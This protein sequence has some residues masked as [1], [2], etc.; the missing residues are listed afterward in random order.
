MAN[1]VATLF[2]LTSPVNY[3]FWEIHIKSTLVLIIYPKA[4]FT[5]EDMLNTLAL[6]QTTDINK[7]TRRNFL[8]F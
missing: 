7:I 6:H 8:G 5:T 1:F 4:L 3:S 2:K